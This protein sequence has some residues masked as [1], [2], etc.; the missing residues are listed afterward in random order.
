MKRA[1]VVAATILAL[2]GCRTEKD[3][4]VTPVTLNDE[5]MGHYCGMSLMEHEGP[6]GQVIL[7]T[8]MPP[9]W[10][11]SALD[12]VAFTMLP[13]EPKDYAGIFVS[14][15]GRADNW[16]DPGADNWIDARSAFYVVGSNA[17]GGMGGAEVVPFAERAVAEGFAATRGGVVKPFAELQPDEILGVGGADFDDPD[18]AEA[19]HAQH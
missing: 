3:V 19:T 6:K 16:A 2:A 17:R 4:E 1:I 13:E 18:D 11:S 8:G 14:D 7:T 9:I 10:F 12:T 15:M 5:A